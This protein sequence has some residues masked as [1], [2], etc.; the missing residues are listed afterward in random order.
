MTKVRNLK[1]LIAI[2]A[3]GALLASVAWAAS[4]RPGTFLGNQGLQFD[5]IKRHDV[6][7]VTNILG[8]FGYK[9]HGF[10]LGV[11]Q[12][13][14]I[15]DGRFT[16]NGPVKDVRGRPA[17]NLLVK[18]RFVSRRR[19]QGI[20]RHRKGDCNTGRVGYAANWQPGGPAG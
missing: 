7:R 12:R 11:R 15:R 10:P 13:L 2:L 3:L 20:F 5:V 6:K 1:V 18:G 16:F 4:P 9:C 17:G 14:A 19:A 8:G